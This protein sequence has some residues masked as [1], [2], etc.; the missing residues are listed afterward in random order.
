MRATRLAASVLALGLLLGACASADDPSA[1][2]VREDLSKSLQKGDDALSKAEADCYA[3]IVVDEVGADA[4]N[5]VGFSDKEP[6]AA[7]AKELGAAAVAARAE[8]LGAG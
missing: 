3:E 8:C 1:E 6:E 4:I 5:D 7:V 2:E